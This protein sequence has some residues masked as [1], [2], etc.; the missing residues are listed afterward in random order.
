M[1]LLLDENLSE[2][3]KRD[4]PEHEVYTILL[5]P[6]SEDLLELLITSYRK[7]SGMLSLTHRHGKEKTFRER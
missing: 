5:H 6:S 2:N 1:K 4:F 3:L 7:P